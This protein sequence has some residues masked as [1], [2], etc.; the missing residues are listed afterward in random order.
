[1]EVKVSLE[2]TVSGNKEILIVGIVKML[3][4]ELKL[5][6][7]E[8]VGILSIMVLVQIGIKMVDEN[9]EKEV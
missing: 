5:V 4:V 1:M 3:N 8:R 2:V 7:L 9:V 6:L